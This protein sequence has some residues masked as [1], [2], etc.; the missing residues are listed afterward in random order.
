M[1]IPAA[2]LIATIYQLEMVLLRSLLCYAR[3]LTSRASV[4]IINAVCLCTAM[5]EALTSSPCR[6]IL[7]L[8]RIRIPIR[9]MIAKLRIFAVLMCRQCSALAWQLLSTMTGFYYASA[10]PAAALPTPILP[11][12]DTSHR[13]TTIKFRPDQLPAPTSLMPAFEPGSSPS[14]TTTKRPRRPPVPMPTVPVAIPAAPV[15]LGNTPG[16]NCVVM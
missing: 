12:N 6:S 4:D 8:A 5:D 14:C 3:M 2:T 10:A 16:W 1:S 13:E 15:V 11:R 9:K 7:F